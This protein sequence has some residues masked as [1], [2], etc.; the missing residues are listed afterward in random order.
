MFTKARLVKR[1]REVKRVEMLEPNQANLSGTIDSRQQKSDGFR[2]SSVD[3]I[4]MANCPFT[5]CN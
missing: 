3:C 1:Q 2:T 5:G 4:A